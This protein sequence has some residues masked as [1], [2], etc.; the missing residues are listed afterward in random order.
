MTSE[1]I[2]NEYN[3][4]TA[5]T[6]SVDT[7]SQTCD[8]GSGTSIGTGTPTIPTI[9]TTTQAAPQGIPGLVPIFAPGANGPGSTPS[10]AGLSP[11]QITPTNATSIAGI[12]IVGSIAGLPVLAGGINIPG[13]G[14]VPAIPGLTVSLSGATLSVANIVSAAL[15]GNFPPDVANRIIGAVGNNGGAINGSVTGAPAGSGITGIPGSTWDANPYFNYS[16][17]SNAQAGGNFDLSGTGGVGLG[18]G[19]SLENY[20]A[21][22]DANGNNIGQFGLLKGGSGQALSPYILGTG[23]MADNG[24]LGSVDSS[25]FS[26]TPLYTVGPGLSGGSGTLTGGNLPDVTETGLRAAAITSAYE[27]GSNQGAT[28]V[29]QSMLNRTADGTQ[30]YSS[31]L[32][33]NVTARNQYSPMSNI[34]YG[35]TSGGGGGGG[36]R[37]SK[38]QLNEILSRPEGEWQAGLRAA[39]VPQSRIDRAEAVLA[40]AKSDGPMIQSARE[41]VGSR[42]EFVGHNQPGYFATADRGGINDNKF[43]WRWN[44]NEGNTEVGRLGTSDGYGNDPFGEGQGNFADGSEYGTNYSTD[45]SGTVTPYSFANGTVTDPT[46]STSTG[47]LIGQPDNTFNNQFASNWSDYYNVSP[48]YYGYG[49]SQISGT[50]NISPNT[51]EQYPNLYNAAQSQGVDWNNIGGTLDPTYSTVNWNSST[52]TDNN[53]YSYST[54]TTDNYSYPTYNDSSYYDS[55]DYSSA[56]DNESYWSGGDYSGSSA[57]DYST[58]SADNYVAADSSDYLGD[59]DA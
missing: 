15:S 38:D 51:L 37:M 11:S 53:G 27:S 39:G 21:V 41:H 6:T 42:T 47:S 46:S 29:F 35:T 28:D 7:S 31:S 3:P 54:P 44:S 10:P 56:Y 17:V 9:P 33:D 57:G 32:F 5:G 58:Y 1:A 14:T 40:D 43:G 49:N 13:V 30:H 52:Y 20:Q 25:L 18:A 59:W 48:T 12:P 34:L 8:L 36:V 26:S 23:T 19:M 22:M 24:G 45:A 55:Y 2:P 16:G 50:G 4:S